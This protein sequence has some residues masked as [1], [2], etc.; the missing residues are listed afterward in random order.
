MQQLK[1]FKFRIYPTAEQNILLQ[2]TFG[3]ARFVWNQLVENFNSWSPDCE[4]PV[5]IIN[6]KI[7]KDKP[8]FSF[9]KEISAGVL[10]QKRIDFDETKKQFF[11][12]KR[13]KKLG[14]PNFKNR[15]GK[16]SFR[17]PNQKFALSQE[18]SSIRLEKIGHVKII[19]DREIPD[20][21]D[22]RSVTISKDPSGKLYASVLVQIDIETKSLTG[23]MTGIDLGIK[24]L[25]ILSDG[26]VINNPKWFRE[27]QAK[28][29]YAQQHLSRKQKGSNRR[30]RQRIKV[31]KINE[32]IRFSRNHFL[33]ET[34]SAIVAEF[35]VI[36]IED[37]NVSGMLKNHKLAKAIA[38]ASWSSFV[39]MLEYKCN[40]Y[41]KT[42]VKIDRFF[43]S[44]KTCSCCGHKL[45][46]LDLGT[47]E[48]ACPSCGTAHDR[49]INAARNILTKGFSDLTGESIEFGGLPETIL[50]RTCRVQT[51]RECQSPAMEQISAKCL[52]VL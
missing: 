29:K 20:D 9:L 27:N 49:D 3:C 31:A 40:W 11:N 24:D 4:K 2:K 25:F 44:S 21:T 37:L 22:Y 8:E 32:K 30:E 17:L 28:L 6:E 1:A 14:R 18:N 16:Q 43:P 48:W 23:K 38:D 42:L 36:C 47:R 19:I 13:K 46:V 51:Q 7:L 50:G 10:Q 52:E 45:D 39:S 41:G 35:D 34:S 12:K 26:Q 15:R 5:E 33:H